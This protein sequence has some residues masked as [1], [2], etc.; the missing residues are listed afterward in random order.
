MIMNPGILLSDKRFCVIEKQVGL[1]IFLQD[2]L[3]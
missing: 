1:S 3:D 2:W